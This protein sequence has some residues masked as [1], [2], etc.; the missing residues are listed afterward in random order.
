MDKKDFE[1]EVYDHEWIE[2]GIEPGDCAIIK[3]LGNEKD[4]VIPEMVD[5]H[6]V[7]SL[8]KDRNY[9]FADYDSTSDITSVVIPNTVTEICD[10]V[11]ANCTKLIN[12]VIP[13]SVTIIE[14]G[15]FYNC[16]SLEEIYI[17]DSVTRLSLPIFNLVGTF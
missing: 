3:Y 17:P 12:V 7:V 10:R 8:G 14:D 11:F 6:K 16:L 13:D 15:A 5:G 2:E 9:M 4:V 1:I